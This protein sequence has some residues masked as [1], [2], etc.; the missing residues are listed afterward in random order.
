M[1]HKHG[2][3]I[4]IGI[5]G[6]GHWGPNHIR[7]FSERQR[8]QVV[9]VADSNPTRLATLQARFGNHDHTRLPPRARSPGC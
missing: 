2:S 4:G 7:V 9:A 5:I 1:T 8:S 3:P 6:C